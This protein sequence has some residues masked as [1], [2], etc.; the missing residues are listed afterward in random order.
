MRAALTNQT[1][2]RPALVVLAGPEGSGKTTF[3]DRKLREA[4]PA[5]V[6]PGPK[7]GSGRTEQ[8]ALLQQGSS[9][10]NKDI[11]VDTTLLSHAKAAGYVTRVIFISTEDPN[12]NVGRVLLRISQGGALVPLASIPGSYDRAH[13]NLKQISKLVDDLMLLDNTLNGRSHRLVARFTGGELIKV[14]RSV[15]QWAERVF[16][17]EFNLWRA[18]YHLRKVRDR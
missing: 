18:K 10:V 11:S 16:G 3:Y 9:F 14:A 13:G 7:A 8:N 2:R 12:L 1:E 15:P 5:L 6:T 4:F 17:E